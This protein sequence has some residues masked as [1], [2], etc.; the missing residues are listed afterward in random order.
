MVNQGTILPEVL[1]PK[2]PLVQVE[3]FQPR[4]NPEDGQVKPQ[5][6]D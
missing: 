4:K 2:A 5:D 3:R 1:K 6:E